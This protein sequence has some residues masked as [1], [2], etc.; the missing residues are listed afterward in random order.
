MVLAVVVP[1]TPGSLGAQEDPRPR[2][3]GERGRSP[4]PEKIDSLKKWRQADDVF[5]Q[6][7]GDFIKNE[8]ESHRWVAEFRRQKK[9]FE[10]GEMSPS[11]ILMRRKLQEITARYDDYL[12]DLGKIREQVRQ[13]ARG[14]VASR[15]VLIPILEDRKSEIERRVGSRATQKQRDELERLERWLTGLDDVE[16]NPNLQLIGSVLGDEIGRELYRGWGGRSRFFPPGREER[17]GPSEGRSNYVWRG[18]RSG[19]EPPKGPELDRWLRDRKERMERQKKG[20]GEFLARIDVEIERIQ[21]QIDAG[22]SSEPKSEQAKPDKIK[23]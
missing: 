12:R 3:R 4:E 7:A 14:A 11:A 23:N 17:D 15:T 10:P 2:R 6:S 21:K 9:D 20:I 16:R 22:D 18:N 13:V 8:K 5:L 19:Q 1:M